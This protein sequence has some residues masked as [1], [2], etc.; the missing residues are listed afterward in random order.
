MADS[1]L[2]MYVSLAPIIIA[3]VLNMVWCSM[4]VARRLNRPLDN[5]AVLRDGRRV[6][7]DNKT[8][9]GLLGMLALGAIAFVLWSLVLQGSSLGQWD[10]F[11]RRHPATF[12]FDTFVGALLGAAYALFELPNSFLKRRLDIA[13]GKEATGARKWFFVVLDQVDSVVGCAVVVA[14]LAVV[15]PWFFL[16]LILVGGVTHILLN[17]GLFAVGLRRNRF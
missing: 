12:A 8:W 17:M 10:L 6:F 13:P 11:H 2:R 16:G 9:K 3:G 14:I 7:G 1:V 4:G 15:T 5:G